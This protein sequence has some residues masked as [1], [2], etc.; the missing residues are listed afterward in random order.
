MAVR[1][2]AARRRDEQFTPNT[3]YWDAPDGGVVFFEATTLASIR[4]DATS[5]DEALADQDVQ[6]ALREKGLLNGSEE[7][8]PSTGKAPQ[9]IDQNVST[10]YVVL[11]RLCNFDCSYCYLPPH[12]DGDRIDRETADRAVD[13]LDEAT[14]GHGRL[15]FFGGE[16][17]LDFEM[18][19][20][21][22]ERTPDSFS[23]VI[24]T[25]GS[26]INDEVAAFFDQH[27]FSVAVSIDGPAEI[28]E[29]ARTLAGGNHSYNRVAEGI[30]ALEDQ[31]TEFQL[32]TTVGEHNVDSL[33]DVVTHLDDKFDHAGIS[34]NHPRFSGRGADSVGGVAPER[35]ANA[36]LELIRGYAQGELSAL[37]TN[38]YAR[39]I[40][41][42]TEGAHAPVHCAGCGRHVIVTPDGKLGPCMAADTL[43]DPS[44]PWW[45]HIDE[46][47][48]FDDYEQLDLFDRWH[49]TLP[50]H[51]DAC[52]GCPAVSICGG[53]CP[54][55][56]YERTGTID[57]VDDQYCSFIKETLQR[58]V[59]QFSDHVEV[60]S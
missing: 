2:N 18:I 34:L 21:L 46:V 7:T 56:A 44:G 19:K 28:H 45:S 31:E 57:G 16:P 17:L 35:L 12:S 53:G 37:P 15:V 54:Y 33:R 24:T 5:V 30:R 6:A 60:N 3:F 38:I 59:G 42:L 36:W 52:D 11:N 48:S 10:L 40:R 55:N 22:V 29:C 43:D 58:V 4:T 23:Y 39:W 14:D 13:M 20:H 49:E 27:D 26:C 41:P 25:N 9:Y 50:R 8:Q 47:N 32:L 1:V 51:R